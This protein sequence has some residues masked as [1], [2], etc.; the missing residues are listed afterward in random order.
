MLA[1]GQRLEPAG[2]R[3]EAT[4]PATAAATA[5]VRHHAHRWFAIWHATHHD[6]IPRDEG[7]H[8]RWSR[9]VGSGRCPMLRDD[10]RC[11]AQRQTHDRQGRDDDACHYD[12]AL[13]DTS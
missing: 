12:T 2:G 6:A 4:P 10:P 5:T 7:V 11:D 8:R 13:E 3:A 1:A 9:P